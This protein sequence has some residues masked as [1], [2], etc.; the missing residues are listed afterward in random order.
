MLR[1]WN[2]RSGI[3]LLSLVLSAGFASAAGKQVVTNPKL[4]DIEIQGT[5]QFHV[6]VDGI[7]I[8]KLQWAVDGITGGNSHLGTISS[9][10]VYTA[11]SEPLSE[12]VAVTAIDPKS[13]TVL[14]TAFVSVESNQAV[15]EARQAWLSG[16]EEAAKH[17]GCHLAVV[18]QQ[19]ES[20]EEAIK[21]FAAVADN[22]SCLALL[23]ISNRPDPGRYSMAWGGKVDGIDIFYISDVGRSRIWNG[24]PSND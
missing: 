23:P 5:Q 17:Y 12:P 15:E 13:K 19:G 1:I 4:A 24:A 10:G 8:G 3:L 20:V 11:P 16:V 2:L 9:A 6:Y 18:Q 7:Q 14:G 22:K 21:L